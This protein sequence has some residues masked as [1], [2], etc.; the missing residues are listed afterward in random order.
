MARMHTDEVDID[1]DL[2]RELVRVQFPE[3][4]DLPVRRLAY[5][6]S[7]NAI[8]GSGRPCRRGCR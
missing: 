4:A 6:G 7:T 1:D 5:G 2:V 3:W 8:F